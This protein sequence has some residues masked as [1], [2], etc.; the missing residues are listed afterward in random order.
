MSARGDGSGGD[1]RLLAELRELPGEEP[2]AELAARVRRRARAELEAA[3]APS[4]TGFAARAWTRVA[5]PAAL[6]VTVVGYLSWA[7]G[8]ANALYR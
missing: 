8:M 3:A 1:D 5:L 2:P 4:W 7:I 6:A